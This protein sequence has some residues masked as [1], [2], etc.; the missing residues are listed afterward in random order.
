MSLFITF[1]GLDLSGKSTQVALLRRRLEDEG[2]DVMVLREPGG[3][4][5][6]ETIRSALL[7]P[8]NDD[9]SDGCELFLFSASRAQLVASVI[10]PALGRGVTVICDRFFDST[11]AYQ[12]GGRGFSREVVETIN[13]AATGGL[14]PDLTFFLDIGVSEVERR[15][16]AR[17]TGVDRM[18]TNGESFRAKVRE[19]Y[20]AI[21]AREKRFCVLRGDLPA[22]TLAQEIWERVQAL[23][24]RHHG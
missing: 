5:I 12:G 9:M 10:R 1:E 6:G 3:T 2:R 13:A 15:M 14:T 7:D 23:E 18:E 17:G 20:L 22:D 19:S 4:P 16:R 21:A 11:T 24:V 8:A